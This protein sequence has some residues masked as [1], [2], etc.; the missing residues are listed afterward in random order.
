MYYTVSSELD[1]LQSN[2]ISIPLDNTEK[3]SNDSMA[4]SNNIF[5]LAKSLELTNFD[6]GGLIQA[7][8]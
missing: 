6:M 5:Y 8:W 4:Q 2:G 3:R 1:N 7:N